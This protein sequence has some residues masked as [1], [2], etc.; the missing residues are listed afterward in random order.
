MSL[1]QKTNEMTSKWKRF[2]SWILNTKCRPCLK[3]FPSHFLCWLFSCVDK[4]IDKLLAIYWIHVSNSK[5]II[6][7]NGTSFKSKLSDRFDRISTNWNESNSN[8]QMNNRR[9]HKRF[10]RSHKR[11]FIQRKREKNRMSKLIQLWKRGILSKYQH[12]C[13]CL[14]MIWGRNI[15]K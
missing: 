4:F 1:L 7:Q 13:Q 5:Q 14:S 11:N 9:L 15:A 6:A 2:L 3:Q 8:K 10:T 12:R